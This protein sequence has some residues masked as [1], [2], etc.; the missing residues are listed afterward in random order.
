MHRI[1]TES[2]WHRGEREALLDAVLGPDR[3]LKSSEA[4]RAGQLP[5][6]AL[7]AFD[8][9]QLVGSLRLWRVREA[10]G[11]AVLLLGPFAVAEAARGRGLGARLMRAG[12]NWA[13]TARFDAVVLVGDLAYYGRFGFEGGLSTRLSMPGSYDAA[14]LLGLELQP[15]ALEALHGTL[16]PA[17]E[18][19]PVLTPLSQKAALS[20]GRLVRRRPIG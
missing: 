4:L 15:G 19:D 9:E 11:K 1:A 12:L 10:S 2:P 6:Q 7:A 8:G 18:R 17:G 13:A 5:L 16:E 14:R 20:H 3:Q